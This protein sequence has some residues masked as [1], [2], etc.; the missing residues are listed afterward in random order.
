[1][2]NKFPALFFSLSI[3]GLA[4]IYVSAGKT[5]AKT[6][7][8]SNTDNSMVGLYVEVTGYVE[9]AR[10]TEDTIFIKLSDGYKDIEVVVFSDL[11]K[12]IGNEAQTLFAK[13]AV[14]SVKGVVDE[15]KGAL[16]II[17]NRVADIRR[18]SK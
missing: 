2:E 4:L 12:A 14:V 16:E 7:S 3:I 13:D 17:P 15:Y 11:K 8:I 5:E 18:L 6:L 10:F 9:S 1:M